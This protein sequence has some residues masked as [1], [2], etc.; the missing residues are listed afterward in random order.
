MS[1][2]P[3]LDDEKKFEKLIRD[4]CRIIYNDPSFELYG[5][6]GEEQ[7]GIDGFRLLDKQM[8]AFQCKKKDVINIK[9]TKLVTELKNEMKDE[10]QKAILAFGKMYSIDKYIFATTFKNTKQLQDFAG[11]LST[12]FGFPVEYWGWDTISD[13]IQKYPEL[14]N[15]Y[16]PQF[17]LS[18]EKAIRNCVWFITKS[19]IE[20]AILQD[21]KTILEKSV[22]YYLINDNEKLVFEIISNNIDIPNTEAIQ[23]AKN[24]IDALQ[25][26][27]AIWI[28]GEGGTGKTSLLIRLAVEFTLQGEF[29]VFINFE[30]PNLTYEIIPEI[31]K[32]INKV[33]RNKEV[34]FFIDNPAFNQD[35]LEFFLS[36]TLNYGFQFNIIFVERSIRFDFN[37]K[38][39]HSICCSWS[40][41][42]RA[43]KN[44]EHETAPRESISKV[45]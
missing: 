36:E 39:K 45:I 5:K 38:G 21:Q 22:D 10:T 26:N 27:E 17:I 15:T 29:A 7:Y 20:E 35:L 13:Y 24:A 32:Y 41:N 19:E 37:Q 2:L 1:Q 40:K 11:S 4:I 25:N 18:D 14:L 8:I 23:K 12:E 33:A 6:S 44:C 16:Y 34:F 31:F 9:D 43:C 30:N 42:N 3:P 28:V